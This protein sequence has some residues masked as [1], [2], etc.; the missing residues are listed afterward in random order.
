VNHADN[1]MTIWDVLAQ[2]KPS[3]ASLQRHVIK[4]EGL[5]NNICREYW[6]DESDGANK[7]DVANKRTIFMASDAVLH[8]IDGALFY[9]Q[10]VPWQEQ[11]NKL[12]EE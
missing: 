5:Y 7:S 11:L 12:R 8:L 10:M 1:Q 4:T 2:E 9:E 3:D 6:L